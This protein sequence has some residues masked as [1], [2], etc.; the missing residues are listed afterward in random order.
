MFVPDVR[1][2]V[3]VTPSLFLFLAG[4]KVRTTVARQIPGQIAGFPGIQVAGQVAVA[5][6]GLMAERQAMAPVAAMGNAATGQ[7]NA[8]GGQAT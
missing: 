4:T 6:A 3:D 1:R 8:Q 2:D 7:T 5:E